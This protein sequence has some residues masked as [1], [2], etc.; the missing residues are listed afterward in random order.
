MPLALAKIKKKHVPKPV[1][2]INV[3]FNDV[4]RNLVVLQDEAILKTKVLGPLKV[5]EL[6]T[7]NPKTLALLKAL[8]LLERPIYVT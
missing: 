5:I 1:R 2:I 4:N 3:A 8:E 7:E 6:Q